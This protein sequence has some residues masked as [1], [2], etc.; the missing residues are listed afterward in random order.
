[1]RAISVRAR[2]S[3][4]R[5]RVRWASSIV[6]TRLRRARWT[7]A[8]TTFERSMTSGSS[9]IA[10]QAYPTGRRSQLRFRVAR[11]GNGAGEERRL[12]QPESPSAAPAA[13]SASGGHDVIAI[14]ASAGG[15]EALR[16]I[17][18]EL[19]A[20]LEAAVLVVLHVP[21]EPPSALAEILDRAG[22]LPAAQARDGEPVRPGRIYVARPTA[23]CLSGPAGSAPSAA[24]ARTTT[25]PRSTRSSAPPPPCTA[26]GRSA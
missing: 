2:S 13:D 14:G 10:G 5:R 17:V 7:T 3:L 6:V 19:P 22:P 23:T 12:S 4:A 1:L 16:E 20:G 11:T 18:A 21:R 25:A 26:R 8:L 24:R 9:A 15:V